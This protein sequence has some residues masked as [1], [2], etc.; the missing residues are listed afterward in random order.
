M[1]WEKAGFE[2]AEALKEHVR[3]LPLEERLDLLTEHFID[4]ISK[5]YLERRLD[6]IEGLGQSIYVTRE[7]LLEYA[8]S[9][10]P[11]CDVDTAWMDMKYYINPKDLDL[12][13]NRRN[14]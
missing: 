8:A 5:V 14:R 2:N 1:A 10:Y 3:S 4:D 6:F 7:E 11:S 13:S 9:F 12:A